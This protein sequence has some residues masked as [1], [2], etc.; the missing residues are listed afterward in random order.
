MFTK[1]EQNG[2]M[3][4][5]RQWTILENQKSFIGGL[6]REKMAETASWMRTFLKLRSRTR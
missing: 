6:F 3:N 1:L 4:K 5:S 2:K